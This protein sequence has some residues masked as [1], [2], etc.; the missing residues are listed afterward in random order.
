MKATTVRSPLTEPTALLRRQA[1]GIVIRLNIQVF[2]TK[3]PA[4]KAVIFAGSKGHSHVV[5]SRITVSVVW[6]CLDEG[7]RVEADLGYRGENPETVK[8]AG[9][10][11][12]DEK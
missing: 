4:S 1:A 6:L 5:K 9:P 2:A 12:S 8:T 3:L 7:E 11:Y 10:L